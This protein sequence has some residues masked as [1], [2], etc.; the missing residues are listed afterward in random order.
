MSTLILPEN[1]G[2]RLPGGAIIP[3]A[4][5]I[6]RREAILASRY[7]FVRMAGGPV[8]EIWKCRECGGKHRYLTLRCK[9]QPFSG[10]TGGLY[11]YFETI[12]DAD[13]LGLLTPLQQR[14]IRRLADDLG[15]GDVTAFARAH[16][17]R[18]RK[19]AS[20]RDLV[21]GAEVLGILEPVSRNMAQRYLDKINAAGGRTQPP[22]GPLT[23]PGL[24][25]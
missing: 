3:S 17:D 20:D 21:M 13:A 19:V 22:L 12:K 8:G 1:G 14:R 18:A 6:K 16:P 15:M 10:I 7:F 25:S 9:E 5:R 24:R 11:G 23:I 2:F 4:E